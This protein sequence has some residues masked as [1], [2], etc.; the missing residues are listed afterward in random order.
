MLLFVA[1]PLTAMM[2]VLREPLTSVFYQYGLFGQE[3]TDR[4]ASTLGF[5]AIGLVGHMVVHVLARAFYAMQDTRTPVTWAIVAVAINIPLM[6]LLVGPMGVEGLALALSIS[7][8]L[9]V[10]GLMWSLHGRIE[11]VDEGAI[12]RSLGRAGIAAVAAGLVMAGGLW[13]AESFAA[14]VLDDA[15]GRLG[16]L[17]ILVAAGAGT[18]VALAMSFGSPELSQLRSVVRRR[19]PA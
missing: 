12:L 13:L 11:G 7:A 17:A 1:A 4:T 16:A 14:V 3:D 9:E 18:F 6:A 19:R 2:V 10:S 15:L 8:V 5:F